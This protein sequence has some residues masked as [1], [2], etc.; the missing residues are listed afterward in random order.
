MNEKPIRIAAYLRVSTTKQAEADLSLPDQRRHAETY[1][2]RMG[3]DLVEVFNEPG[4]SALDEDRPEFQRMI[5]RACGP[6]RPFDKILVHSFSR[7][8]RDALHSEI[9]IRRLRRAG[10]EVVSATQEFS[11]DPT[12]EMARKF[13]NLFDEYSSRENAKHTRRAMIENARQGFWNGSTAPFGYRTETRDR[14]GRKE[15]RVLVIDEAEA[16]NVRLAFDLCQGRTGREMGLKAIVNYMNERGLTR[17]G[18]PWAIGSL[19]DL[20]HDTTYVGT[21][22]FNR[23]DSRAKTS[24]PA[25]EWIPVPVPSIIDREVFDAVQARLMERRP[26]RVPGRAL[27][28]PTMLA[29]IA[30]CGRCGAAMIVNTGKGGT[31]RYYACSTVIRKGRGHCQGQRVRMDR[32]DNAILTLL[33]ERIFHPDRLAALLAENAKR[34]SATQRGARE[35]LRQV[36]QAMGDTDAAITRLIGLVERGLMTPDDPDLAPRL[37]QLRLRRNEFVADIKRAEG[38]GSGTSTKLDPKALAKLCAAMKQRFVEGPPELRQAY[39][40]LFLDKAELD[41]DRVMVRGSKALLTK[42]ADAGG[43]FSV[44]QVLTYARSWRPREDSNL[45]P[46]V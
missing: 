12:G 19:H 43:S 44:P 31:Y 3:W 41:G 17:R 11:T 15:K 34:A 45:R 37:A 13:M 2:A 6:E 27:S 9:Y 26:S 8:S 4:A 33:S 29:G 38:L 18:R 7:F 24:R 14:R 10:V 25:G 22:Y 5:D 28:S 42:F 23:T 40:R 30:R 46:T 16:A 39:M 32:L 21:A 35:R 36:R 1:C 20:L